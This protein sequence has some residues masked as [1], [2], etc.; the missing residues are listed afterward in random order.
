M[1]ELNP[2]PEGKLKHYVH[3]N[4]KNKIQQRVRE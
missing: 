4:K 2:D 3:N 1:N